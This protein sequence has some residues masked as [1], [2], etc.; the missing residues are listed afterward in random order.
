MFCF[1]TRMF[2]LE[3]VE[4]V[5][6]EGRQP[7]H[8]DVPA[9]AGCGRT[10]MAHLWVRRDDVRYGTGRAL[11]ESRG[12]AGE[13]DGEELDLGEAE[14][15]DDGPAVAS[16]ESAQAFGTEGLERGQLHREG[17]EA[18]TGLIDG[19]A[20]ALGQGLEGWVVGRHGGAVSGARRDG[21]MIFGGE[22][23]AR[24]EADRETQ[25]RMGR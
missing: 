3:E 21:A 1:R 25:P 7:G 15:G 6:N 12:N 13:M 4:W 18:A 9:M 8:S 10:K 19:D 16:G 23:I 17:D 2:G 5:I 11:D 24:V 14:A 20:D 22:K